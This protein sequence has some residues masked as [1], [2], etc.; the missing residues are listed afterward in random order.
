ML[1]SRGGLSLLSIVWVRREAVTLEVTRNLLGQPCLPC[2]GPVSLASVGMHWLSEGLH[3][4]YIRPN[5][6]TPFG[7]SSVAPTNLVLRP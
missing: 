1:T 5:P 2:K 7:F 3:G 6:T 4:G